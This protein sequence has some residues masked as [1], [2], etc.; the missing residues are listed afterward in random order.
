M[1]LPDGSIL[2]H[3][4][5]PYDPRKAHEYYLKTR[6]LKGR[7]KGQSKYTVTFDSGKKVQLNAK[8]LKKKKPTLLSVLL[9]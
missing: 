1:R 3:G 2:M 4:T 5:T 9:I 8:Q 6:H 7:K